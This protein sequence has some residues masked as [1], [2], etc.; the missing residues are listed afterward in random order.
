[1]LSGVRV[2][3]LPIMVASAFWAVST[4]PMVEYSKKTPSPAMGKLGKGF[5]TLLSNNSSLDRLA[6]NK[7]MESVST[8]NVL[9][10]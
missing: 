10:T 9:I 7:S 3:E 5:A 8:D 6:A 1:M 2:H 4:P